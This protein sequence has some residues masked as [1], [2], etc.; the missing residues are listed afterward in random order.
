MEFGEAGG[1][2]FIFEKAEKK[3]RREGAGRNAAKGG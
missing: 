3:E 1:Q 2:H